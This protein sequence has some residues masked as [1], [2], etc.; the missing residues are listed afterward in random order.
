VAYDRSLVRLKGQQAATNF[1][2]SDYS[3]QLAEHL[4]MTARVDAKEAR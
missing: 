4:E 3:H 2:L 1:P